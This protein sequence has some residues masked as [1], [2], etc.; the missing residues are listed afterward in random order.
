MLALRV[1][2]LSALCAPVSTVRSVEELAPELAAMADG[3]V[4]EP[5]MICGGADIWN[6]LTAGRSSLDAAKNI[7]WQ[8]IQSYKDKHMQEQEMEAKLATEQLARLRQRLEE[9]LKEEAVPYMTEEHAKE[10]IEKGVG[11][12]S[13][14]GVDN[15]VVFKCGKPGIRRER[16][17][18]PRGAYEKSQALFA[19]A[20]KEFFEKKEAKLQRLQFWK[21]CNDTLVGSDLPEDTYCEEL[22]AYF[23]DAAQSDSNKMLGETAGGSDKIKDQLLQ[24]Q[25]KLDKAKSSIEEC[26]S[27]YANLESFRDELVKLKET[28]GARFKELQ[29]AELALAD[30]MDDLADMEDDLQAQQQ[31]LAEATKL[32]DEAGAA[33]E[34]A[35]SALEAATKQEND[36]MGKV[37]GAQTELNSLREELMKARAADDKIGKLKELVTQTMMMMVQFSEAALQ[38]P[39]LKLQFPQDLKKIAFPNPEETEAATITKDSIRSMQD[40]CESTAKPAFDEVKRL[41]DLDLSP[42]CGFK[43]TDTIFADLSKEVTLRAKRIQTDMHAVASWLN[44]YRLNKKLTMEQAKAQEDQLI[45]AGQLPYLERVKGV[46]YGRNSMFKYLIA[47]RKN[48]PHHKLV[49]Q[50]KAA[51]DELAQK[52]EEATKLL[53]ELQVALAAA[54]GSLADATDKLKTAI[55]Q[56]TIA[57][58]KKA[59]LEKTVAEMEESRKKLETDLEALKARV[60]KAKKELAE[61]TQALVTAYEAA[62]TSADGSLA[63]LEADSAKA[64]EQIRKLERAIAATKDFASGKTRPNRADCMDTCVEDSNQTEAARLTGVHAH[65]AA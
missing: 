40:Y 34:D 61:A 51:V 38:E 18:A 60:E 65:A 17:R 6:Q 8:K 47:W 54:Q 21:V 4:K 56:E 58:E 14:D 32:L 48:G 2:L 26:N 15:A 13:F 53:E 44:P 5:N 20:S 55:E 63:E 42:L 10:L 36:L 39:I 33:T 19:D 59:A 46:Y 3:I 35:R 62:V 31:S 30:A 23:A 29:Q 22:C 50:L 1:A 37:G 57:A 45:E 11:E 7:E 28:Y 16:K 25:E 24:T 41:V 49:A 9:V 43:D 27:D 64:E 52:E 12:G